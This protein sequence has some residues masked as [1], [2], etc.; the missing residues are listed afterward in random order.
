[1]KD[2]CL[3][4]MNLKIADITI[5]LTSE[6]SDLKFEIIEPYK[7]FTVDQ[8]EPDI[9]LTLSYKDKLDY[10]FESKIFDSNGIWA[11]YSYHG[12]KALMIDSNYP[13]YIVILNND[14]KCGHIYIQ[15]GLNFPVGYPLDE[16]LIINLLSLGYGIVLH[17][18]GIC[19][20]GRGIIFAGNSGSG[21]STL[22]QI[23]SNIEG[24]TVLSDDRI[25]IRNI[26]GCFWMYGT[27]WNG[28]PDACSSMKIPLHNI[29]FIK[30][31][32]K[33]TLHKCTN[34]EAAC[35]LLEKSFITRWDRSGTQFSLKF[36]EELIQ[37][38]PYRELS[39]VPD[40]KVVEFLRN[41]DRL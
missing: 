3:D 20:R 38:I 22:A 28:D 8:C 2:I 9:T 37:E 15:K 18:C 21:K 25:I 40:E 4:K 36:I 39:F 14:Y 16:I 17:A 7:Q 35:F 11:L 26:D 19:D 34:I 24:V 32:D 23:W 12:K 5:F 13:P 1:M 29:F 31:G 27:P 10:P 6:I 41:H 30:H 33:N